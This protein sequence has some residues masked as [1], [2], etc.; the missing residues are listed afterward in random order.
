MHM[1]I[2]ETSSVQLTN[3]L[4]HQVVVDRDALD[5]ASVW[6]CTLN[7]PES[8]AYVSEEICI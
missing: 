1:W 2:H 4:V 8:L 7:D 3:L 6:Q 5:Q